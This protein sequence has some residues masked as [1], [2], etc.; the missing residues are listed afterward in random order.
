VNSTFDDEPLIRE[1]QQPPPATADARSPVR[2]FALIAIV[3]LILGVI[4]AWLWESNGTVPPR[5]ITAAVTG[6]EAAIATPAVERPLPPLAQMDTFLRAIISALS[7]NPLLARWLATDD[8][9]RQMADAIDKVSRG[10]SPARDQPVLKPQ[11]DFEV[12]G[13]QREL[14]IDPESYRRYDRFVEIVASLDPAAVARVYRTI[15]P[16]LDEAYRALGRSE[17][18]VDQAVAVALDMLIATPTV[19]DPIRIVPGKG[20]TYAFADPRLE[21]LTPA[22]KQLVRMGPQ[23]LEMIHSRL[24]EIADAIAT[25]AKR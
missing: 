9:I 24:R 16:R 4:G 18:S 2:L 15:Q 14:T 10:Q 6:T 20:A 22:Q 17:G 7:S 25:S 1:P 3:G 19:K 12:R 11:G 23:N 5:N 21:A 13:A 8:L